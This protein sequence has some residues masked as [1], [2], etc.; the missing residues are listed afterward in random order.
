M[1]TE[2]GPGPTASR[3]PPPQRNAWSWALGLIVIVMV[4]VLSVTLLRRGVGHGARGLPPGTLIPPF[5]APLVTS[6]VD[7]DVNLARRADSGSAGRIAA[8]DVRIAGVL[9]SC[10]LTARTPL[11]LGFSTFGG[12]CLRQIDLLQRLQLKQGDR[13]TVAVVAIR[14]DRD[15]WRR[16]AS[17]RWTIPLLYDRDGGLTTA[18]GVEV[19]PQ[20]L[21]IERGGRVR[22]VAIGELDEQGLATRVRALRTMGRR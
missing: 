8:C 13:I 7:G 3:P 12:R 5:A 9:T 18:Y 22:S 1:A 10:A 2:D 11:V 15:R 21:F 17:G 6:R 4:V 20:T 16:L 14:G 19:C